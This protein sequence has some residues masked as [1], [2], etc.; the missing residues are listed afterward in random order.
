MREF[1]IR[2]TKRPRKRRDAYARDRRHRRRRRPQRDVSGSWRDEYRHAG[3]TL[4]DGGADGE[5]P[6]RYVLPDVGTVVRDR[7]GEPTDELLVVAMHDTRADEYRLE[8]VDGEPTVADVNPGYDPAAPVVGAVYR[9]DV[10]DT[11]GWRTVDELRR[12]VARDELRAY[13]F[14]ADRLAPVDDDTPDALGG[15]GA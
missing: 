15:G 3:V 8:A 1:A 13:S 14:P 5:E 2:R 6:T 12:A 11:D 7:D 9:D 10:P 4:P